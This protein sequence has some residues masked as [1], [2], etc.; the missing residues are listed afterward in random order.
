MDAVPAVGPDASLAPAARRAPRVRRR[1]H[2]VGMVVRRADGVPRPTSRDRVRRDGAR[3]VSL[4]P[5]RSTAD[6]ELLDLARVGPDALRLG[7]ARPHVLNDEA[8]ARRLL[9]F[10]R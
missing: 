7:T 2:L 6:A 4:P 9:P 3:L 10:V 1:R 8:A 5:T